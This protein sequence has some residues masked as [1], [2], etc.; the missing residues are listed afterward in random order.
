[1]AQPGELLPGLTESLKSALVFLQETTT[2]QPPPEG[3]SLL[4]TKNE[5]LLSYLQ[6]LVFLIILK[7]RERP[8]SGTSLETASADEVVKTLV[9]LRIYLEKGVR[10]LESRLKY[11]LD[12]LL[13]AAAE[14][15]S[16]TIAQAPDRTPTSKIHQTNGHT[17]DTVSNSDASDAPD[18][19]PL[20]I[21]RIPDLAHCPNP[22]SLLPPRK[23]SSA[24]SIS[25]IYQPPRLNPT[26]PPDSRK[27]PPKPRKSH[28]L[29]S[30]AREELT[31]APFA[32]PSIGSGSGLKGRER[33]K[34]EERRG[35]EEGRLVRLPGEK[36]KRR[37]G[38]E[39]FG[40][41]DLLGG[42]G[43]VD[44]AGG[45]GKRRKGGRMEGRQER[46]GEAWERRAKRGVG[47]RK[48]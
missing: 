5:L 38:G 35:Y 44:F 26:A 14:E 4:D 46:V 22:S 33:E 13:F 18:T 31:D 43:G 8:S 6:N 20:P 37:R 29:D 16:T 15:V 23:S 2:I 11:Q 39:G 12:K 24:P 47:K 45:D 32:E 27:V 30:F 34:E 25:N 10:P 7:L 48:R 42:I 40:E 21:S 19:N 36:R 1:M 41:D 9:S 3:I 28:L 17:S